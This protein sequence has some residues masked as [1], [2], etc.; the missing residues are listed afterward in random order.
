[1][2]SRLY[3]L[4]SNLYDTSGIQLDKCKGNMGFVNI[5]SKQIAL[6]HSKRQKTKKVKDLSKRMLKKN[7]DHTSWC[8]DCD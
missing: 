8:W 3:K 7:F 2:A 5:S 4:A 1:M 6:L